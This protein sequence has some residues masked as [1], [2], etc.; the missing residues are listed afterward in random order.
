MR[1]LR[2]IIETLQTAILK[3]QRQGSRQPTNQPNKGETMTDKKICV[4]DSS[5]KEHELKGSIQGR[6][7]TITYDNDEMQGEATVTISEEQTE[8]EQIRELEGIMREQHIATEDEMNLAYALKGYKLE[9][10]E[11]VLYIRTGLRDTQQ[12]KDDLNLE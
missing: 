1:K 9:T 3:E 7:I 6:E 8:Q 11:D 4:I 2:T 5:G 12:L 10:V